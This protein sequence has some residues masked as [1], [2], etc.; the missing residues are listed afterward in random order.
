MAFP[1]TR[2]QVRRN[3]NLSSA[4]MNFAAFSTRSALTNIDL[5]KG[6]PSTT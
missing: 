6:P 3:V 5:P 4:E 2:T 1:L